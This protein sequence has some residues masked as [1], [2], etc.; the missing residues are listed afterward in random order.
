MPISR[1]CAT[2]DRRGAVGAASPAPPDSAATSPRSPRRS[3][4]YGQGMQSAEL[5]RGICRGAEALG[6]AAPA[7]SVRCRP[8][9]L[10]R[11]R[12]LVTR[13][14]NQSNLILDPDLDSYYTM[15]L[16]VL[17][18]PDLLDIES[19]IADRLASFVGAAHRCAPATARSTSFSKAG[20]MPW[21]R[22]SRATM[23]KR[24]PPASRRCG[25]MLDPTAHKLAAGDRS[26]PHGV[27][28]LRRRRARRRSCGA[29][30]SRRARSCSTRCA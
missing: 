14:G 20:S 28:Q 29:G 7:E 30:C 18:F 10:E 4:R 15:S 13:L 8:R 26:L 27:A 21:P 25:P 1:W 16:F 2:A 12:A 6:A 3:P 19:G 5:Q 23:P 17:R 22:A 9:A 11:G 24:L